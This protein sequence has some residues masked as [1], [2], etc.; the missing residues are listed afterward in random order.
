MAL[1][2]LGD[3]TISVALNGTGAVGN[4][5]WMDLSLNHYSASTQKNFNC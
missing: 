5:F 3:E 4:G 1:L 2:N